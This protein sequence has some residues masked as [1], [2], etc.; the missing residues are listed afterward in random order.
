MADTAAFPPVS[1][2]KDKHSRHSKRDKKRHRDPDAT[3]T[4]ERKH[5]KSRSNAVSPVAS[6]Q[7]GSPQTSERRKR[8]HER[9]EK[10]KLKKYKHNQSIPEADSVTP[11]IGIAQVSEGRES[12]A[13]DRKQY[14]EGEV[15]QQRT[16]NTESV[17]VSSSGSQAHLGRLPTKK[18]P[19][20]TQTISQYL[21][22]Y[23]SGMAEPIRGYT[24]QYL[25]PLLNRYVRA[26]G[27]VLLAYRNP[28]IGAAP[29]QGAL[30]EESGIEDA[31]T[32]E[33]INEYAVAFGWLTVEVDL[34]RPARDAWLE[35]S[36]KIQSEGHIGV[37]CWSRFQA[38][39]EA[40]RLP[41]DWHWV[42]LTTKTKSSSNN[43]NSKKGKGEDRNKA[44]MEARLPTP[45]PVEAHENDNTTQLHD[46][47]YWV[48]GAGA[49]IGE[50]TNLC[51]RI[52]NYEVG[53]SDDYGYLIIEGTMLNEEDEKNKALEEIETARRQKL[54]HGGLLRKGHKRLPEF[55]MTKFG[56]DEAQEAE[57]DRAQ[58]WKS[59]RPGSET[60]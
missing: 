4:S 39:I 20:Y 47:G 23:P 37:V 52:K 2:K 43:N 60:E 56:M 3:D 46:T 44:V 33:S 14:E 13:T 1:D 25:K 18:H 32:L 41:R 38:S 59:S 6:G 26:F 45:E 57:N 42:D 50:G 19:F 7:P 40:G 51:F 11:D 15:T 17:G 8:R 21:P 49:R 30:T 54:K 22:L 28:R 31:T 12:R 58:M 53:D 10:K 9:E 34:F 29:G 24:D 27:G 36:V 35:G 48:D 16:P 5:K 55:G